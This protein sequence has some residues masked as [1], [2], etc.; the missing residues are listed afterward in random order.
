MERQELDLHAPIRATP[1]GHSN[2]LFAGPDGRRALSFVQSAARSFRAVTTTSIVVVMRPLRG[3]TT[4]DADVVTASRR[5]WPCPRVRARL[6]TGGR[7]D[8]TREL[9]ARRSC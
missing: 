3:S 1:E 9:A 8:P 5:A 2:G 7:H 6:A 4:V